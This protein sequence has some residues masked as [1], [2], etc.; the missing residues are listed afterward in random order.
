[1]AFRL[2]DTDCETLVCL[3]EHRMLTLTQ[4][5][6]LVQKNKKALWRRLRGLEKQQ[7]VVLNKR[8]LGKARGRP[9]SVLSFSKAG[10]ELLK[11]K[12]LINA[13]APYEKVTAEKIHCRD[14]QLMLN[15]FRIHLN[16]VKRLLPRHSL[17]RSLLMLTLKP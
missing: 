1:M 6:L 13:I 14:H 11:A 7:L 15:W 8:E 2:R 17:C 4:I 9:E 5:A 16:L 12:G 10:V 3:A